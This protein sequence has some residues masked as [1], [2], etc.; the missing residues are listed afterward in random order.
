[1]RSGG[2][3]RTWS[4]AILLLIVSFLGTAWLELRPVLA[5]DEPVAAL[6]PPWWDADR[7]L[8]AA[9]AAGGAV[10]RE[11]AW[12]SILV[13]KSDDGDLGRRL[14]ASGAWLL[15]NP[16]ALEACLKEKT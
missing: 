5:A 4:P 3:W 8:T 11:G 15:V 12:P 14:Y 7:A 9:A 1:M 2:R 16:K 6:F 13:L 10:V